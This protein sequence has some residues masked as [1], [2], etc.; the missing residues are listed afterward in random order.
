MGS[1]FR[2][3]AASAPERATRLRETIEPLV[4]IQRRFSRTVPV[5]QEIDAGLPY[6]G[7]PLGC[8][9]EVRS[10]GLACGIAFA[11][12]LAARISSPGGQI[13]YVASDRTLY[14]LGLLAYGVQ[15][16]RLIHVV[17]RR[18]LDLAWATL[19]AL[20]C[21]QVDAVLAVVKIAD[22]TL[23]RRFQLAAES[24]G[25]TGF[26]LTDVV[27]RATTPVASVITRWQ[28]FPIPA[29]PESTF[30]EPCWEIE[31]SYCRG[32]RPGRWNAAW[33]NG[34]LEPL[35]SKPVRRA[36]L[37]HPNTLAG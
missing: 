24:H 36:G 10:S 19:E 21:P 12:M 3:E 23:C 11:A 25:A 5:S 6:R 15:P 31:L 14:P 32:G 22:L 4:A 35:A 37:L 17:V 33:R 7:L 13:V 26:L 34:R 30:E 1:V 9:H 2:T 29:P 28:V 20:R 16:E 27:S 8:I 18:P